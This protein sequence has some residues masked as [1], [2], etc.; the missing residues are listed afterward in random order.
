L[1]PIYGKHNLTMIMVAPTGSGS[2][3]GSET[4][5]STNP[6]HVLFPISPK[7]GNTTQQMEE[8]FEKLEHPPGN[9][10]LLLRVQQPVNTIHFSNNISSHTFTKVS[11]N[12]YTLVKP[13]RSTVYGKIVIDGKWM[14]GADLKLNDKQINDLTVVFSKST[15]MFT[16]RNT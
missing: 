4:Y 2:G 6:F 11:N 15:D 3:S 10:A 14:V 16:V 13:I 8:T 9:L 7:C 12:V 5:H 1:F